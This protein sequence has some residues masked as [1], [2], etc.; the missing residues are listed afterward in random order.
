[1]VKG[2]SVNVNFFEMLEQVVKCQNISMTFIKKDMKEIPDF[3]L[4]IRSG[5]MTPEAKEIFVNITSEMNQENVVYFVKDYFD[6]EYCIMSIPKE[7][8]SRGD[9]FILGP[10]QDKA[11]SEEKLLE[12]FSAK[13][14]PNCYVN[15]LRE[16]YNI[17]PVVADIEQW[18]MLCQSMCQIL[19]GSERAQVKYMSQTFPG[20]EYRFDVS[21]NELSFRIIEERYAN[22]NKLLKAVTAG[23]IDES[24]EILNS[25]GQYKLAERYKNPLRDLRNGLISLNTLLRKAV[26][27]GGVHPVYVDELSTKMAKKIELLDSVKKSKQMQTE[28]VRKY[29]MLVRNNSV[30]GYAPVIQKTINYI[31]INLAEDIS[32]KHLAEECSMNASYLSTLFKKEM[33]MTVTDY[34]N[35]QR[36]QRAVSMLNTNNMQI[37]DVAAECG[38]CDVNYFRKLFKKQIGMTPTEYVK[39]I[40]AVAW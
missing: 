5:L 4:G 23:K 16:Y 7:E 27:M 17:L 11:L 39:K 10:Y 35:Q 37:Q 29:C 30:R 25:L 26:E 40:K 20:S 34:I 36:I 2:D 31:N 32:L 9:Y 14:I 33:H 13:N 8:R 1:M 21:E 28:L 18:R 19:N 22:E 15:E 12:L 3:D 24:L 6:A 38:I